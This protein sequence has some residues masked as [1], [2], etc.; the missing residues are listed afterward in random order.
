VKLGYIADGPRFLTAP[1]MTPFVY[2]TRH[3]GN[4]NTGHEWWF[5]PDLDDEMRF[6]I[7]EFLKT[8]DDVNY[9]GDY[10]FE[11]PANLPDNVRMKKPLPITQKPGARYVSRSDRGPSGR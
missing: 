4:W 1:G 7:I 9:P 2:D 10:R 11:R 5:Y 3:L 8:F 6:D